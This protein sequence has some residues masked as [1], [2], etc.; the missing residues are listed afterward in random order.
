MA[1][2]K[3]PKLKEGIS[4][5]EFDSAYNEESYLLSYGGKNWRISLYA[6]WIIYFID[7]KRT[8]EMI[9][10]LVTQKIG[11][12]IGKENII[13]AIDD[14]L[15]KRGLL[16][17]TE[18]SDRS[19]KSGI[20]QFLWL[21]I[22][23]LNKSI[24]NK[25]AGLSILF[26][27][28]LFTINL[29]FIGISL[30]LLFNEYFSAKVDWNL[31][32]A[33]YFYAIPLIIISTWIHEFGHAAA[34]M[35]YGL[36]PQNIGFAFYFTI[37]VLYCDVNCTW[38]LKRKERVIVDLGGIY[39]QFIYFSILFVAGQYFD[40]A[41]L[42]LASMIGVVSM[43]GNFNPLIKM[44]G[45]WCLS[46]WFG[47]PNL[48]DASTE[49]IKAGI[50]S[51][52][53][54]NHRITYHMNVGKSEKLFFC[55]YAIL[56]NCFL[57]MI[58]IF[59]FKFFVKIPAFIRQTIQTYAAVGSVKE[60]VIALFTSCF[61]IITVVLITRACYFTILGNIKLIVDIYKNVKRSIG[62][63]TSVCSESDREGGLND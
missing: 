58:M 54:K 37:P 61:F 16:E 8:P 44:D 12:Q 13:R 45:Y 42:K 5:R 46:D 62:R 26:N 49:F 19:M 17:G 60:L 52:F 21:K 56:F 38:Q 10:D 33:H 11:I 40:N 51:V 35:R 48:H 32:N 34:C 29:F 1:D 18:D 36:I 22:P 41:I 30:I 2:N 63:T 31:Y 25:C 55:I 9:A 24:I 14:F 3:Y 27:P 28:R 15:S 20:S 47:I 50:I 23:L 4:V 6:Y 59:M 57:W 53:S 43:L 7:G 39:T